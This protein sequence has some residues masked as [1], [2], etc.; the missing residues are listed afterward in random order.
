MIQET[1]A[2]LAYAE[3]HLHELPLHQVRGLA[4]AIN[5]GINYMSVE[6]RERFKAIEDHLKQKLAPYRTL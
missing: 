4:N 2:L 5:P 6:Q 3:T 1:E